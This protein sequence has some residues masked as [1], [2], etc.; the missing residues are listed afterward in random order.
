[1]TQPSVAE[2]RDINAPATRIFSI[3]SN[4]ALQPEVDGTGML[5]SAVD[6]AVITKVGDVFFIEMTHWDRG[7]YVMENRVV[8][9]EQDRRIAWEPVAQTSE[10]HDFDS[11]S[12]HLEPRQWGWQLEPLSEES[13]RVTEFFDGSR[14]SEGLRSFIKDGEFWRSA[15][16]TS[17]DNLERMATQSDGA[18]REPP[19]SETASQFSELFR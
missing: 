12:D 7:D 3:L 19:Q 18:H 4:P 5:R 9:F 2:S 13:T 11:D 16:V 1:M 15:M 10:N 17:L 8:E 6:N 14:L